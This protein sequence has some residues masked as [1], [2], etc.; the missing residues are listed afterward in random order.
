MLLVNDLCARAETV[1]S[2]SFLLL[3]GFTFASLLQAMHLGHGSVE[4]L[5]AEVSALDD[6]Q[7]SENTRAA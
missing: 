2:R 3:E 5:L 7:W 4:R 6:F 1:C